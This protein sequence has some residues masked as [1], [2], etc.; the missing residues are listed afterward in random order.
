MAKVVRKTKSTT[1]DIESRIEPVNEIESFIAGLIYGRSGTGKTTVAATFPKP[2]LILDIREKGTD[3]IS[4]VEG[5]NRIRIEEWAEIEEVYWYVKSGRGKSLKTIIIDQVGAMQDLAMVEALSMKNKKPGDQVTKQDFGNAAG[6][7]KVWLMNYRDLVDE[8]KHVLF[9]SHDRVTGGDEEDDN[10]QI[11][12]V[13]G[14]RLM[15]S[16]SSFLNGLVGF[17]GNTYIRE[18]FELVGGKRHRRTHWSMRLGPHPYYTTKIRSPVGFE[19]PSSI[20]NP[21]YD[22]IAAI[23]RGEYEVPAAKPRKLKRSK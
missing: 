8:S 22:D 17:I 13:V 2:S 3:S 10:G 21:A 9:L 1:N 5:V 18:E 16:V 11:D 14:A 15:P 4:N 20:D 7:M 12:P 23:I 6:L 19:I